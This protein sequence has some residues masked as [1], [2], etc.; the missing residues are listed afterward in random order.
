MLMIIKIKL[1]NNSWFRVSLLWSLGKLVIF[2][3]DIFNEYLFVILNMLE[4]GITSS[5]DDQRHETQSH[6]LLL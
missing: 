4:L 6:E 1:G 3:F 2:T 5:P